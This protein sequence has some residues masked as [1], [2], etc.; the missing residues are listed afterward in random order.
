MR[1]CVVCL[2]RAIRD[3]AVLDKDF[4]GIL[5]GRKVWLNHLVRVAD[6]V[7]YEW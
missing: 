1:L 4:V 5:I 6:E 7:G 3:L 2:A